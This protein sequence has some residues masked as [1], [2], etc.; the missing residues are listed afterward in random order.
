[1]YTVEYYPFLNEAQT[2]FGGLVSVD[3][4]TLEEALEEADNVVLVGDAPGVQVYSEDDK[5]I[6]ICSVS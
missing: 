6:P 4:E 5:E 2:E 3:F 1:M